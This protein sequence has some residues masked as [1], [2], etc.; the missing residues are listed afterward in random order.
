MNKV[1]FGETRITT[2]TF[3]AY[4]N[5]TFNIE[6]IFEKIEIDSVIL[7]IKYLNKYK[8]NVKQTVSFRNSITVIMYLEQFKKEVN[9]KVFLNGKVQLTGVKNK[10]HVKEAMYVFESKS[11]NI[12]GETDTEVIVI[13]NIIYNKREHDLVLNKEQTKYDNIKI[14]GSPDNVNYKIVGERKDNDFILF[15]RE[16]NIKEKVYLLDDYF[17]ESK[18][19]EDHVKKI[20]DTNG[21]HIGHLKFIFKWKRK[22]IT[23]KGNDFITD[24][25]TD[26]SVL[27][28]LEQS[29]FGECT[30]T[31]SI[32]N[33]YNNL[34]G[35]I[36]VFEFVKP[37][38]SS[39]NLS[40]INIV[41]NAFNTNTI[42]TTLISNDFNIRPF[43]INSIFEVLF[44]KS[45]KD[46]SLC[47][48]L[49]IL[50]SK[51]KLNAY[52]NPLLYD[53]AINLK[54]Y[55]E[56]DETTA[57]GFNHILSTKKFDLKT[58]VRIFGSGKI[59]IHGC[60]NNEQIVFVKNIILDVFNEYHQ[61]IFKNKITDKIE[62]IDENIDIFDLM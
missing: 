10:E 36:A 47:D 33:K 48:L 43:N 11:K 18:K 35:K 30:K 54:L 20:Y 46:I 39:T 6:K 61:T 37:I 29:E 25:L 15:C 4:Y 7:G 23:I 51:C 62:N 41:F 49:Y 13:D 53:S 60:V 1:T 14:Y 16:T 26:K 9:M 45:Q 52:Y 56:L 40:R 22:N 55:F 27:V 19:T 21:N 34:I 58:S 2:T 5:S 57:T 42:N 59:S 38:V 32:F 3:E 50:T 12:L 8:G 17:V 28:N 31:I 24:K 44:E